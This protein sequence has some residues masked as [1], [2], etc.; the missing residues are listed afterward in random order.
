MSEPIFRIVYQVS[1]PYSAF[2]IVVVNNVVHEADAMGK[3]MKGKSLGYI[4]GWVSQRDGTVEPVS[5]PENM[6]KDSKES[7]F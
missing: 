3:W 4:E 5:N 1:L 2:E 6:K 7:Q